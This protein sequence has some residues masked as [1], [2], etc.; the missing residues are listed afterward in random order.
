MNTYWGTKV[1]TGENVLDGDT[2]LIYMRIRHQTGGD[3]ARVGRQQQVLKSIMTEMSSMNKTKLL[4]VVSELT[5]Y[6]RTGYSSENLL[7]LATDALM[8]GWFNYKTVNMS[9]PDE[10]CAVG[11][12][13]DGAWYW[14]VDFPLAAQDLQNAIFGKSNIV[15]LENREKWI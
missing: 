1:K 14:V 8:N 13:I 4:S 15:L 12:T 11:S 10:T 7:T 2:A 3:T 9:F 6:V 5:K